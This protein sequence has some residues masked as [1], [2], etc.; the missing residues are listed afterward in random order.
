MDYWK[1]WRKTV[2]FYPLIKYSEKGKYARHGFT[3]SD[4]CLSFSWTDCRWIATDMAWMRLV[5]VIRHFLPIEATLPAVREKVVTAFRSLQFGEWRTNNTPKSLS[6]LKFVLFRD[7]RTIALKSASW[8]PTQH[9]PRLCVF[10]SYKT[11]RLL[12]YLNVGK[13]LGQQLHSVALQNSIGTGWGKNQNIHSKSNILFPCPSTNFYYFS[14]RQQRLL[15]RVQYLIHKSCWTSF[16]E[17]LE[18][19]LSPHLSTVSNSIGSD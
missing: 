2:N 7:R 8:N 10:L 1:Y 4:R 12:G 19:N 5:E 13:E 14:F 11:D 6:L 17:E 3:I 18:S 9:L 15:I 16:L